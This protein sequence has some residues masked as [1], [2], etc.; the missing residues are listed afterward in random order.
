MEDRKTLNE[1]QPYRSQLPDLKKIIVW[2]DDVPGD[3]DDVLSWEDVI[4][5]GME[6][7]N[8]ASILERQR[9]MAINQCCVLVYTSG[10]TG[11]PKGNP[12]CN[13]DDN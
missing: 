5:L 2:D 10:T 13:T 7:T 4:K 3:S 6:D 12:H 11:I 8:D 9:N 1:L